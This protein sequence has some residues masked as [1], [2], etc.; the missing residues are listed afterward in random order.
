MVWDTVHYTQISLPLKYLAGLI[1]EVNS[2]GCSVDQI[3]A[4]VHKYTIKIE[5]NVSS[6]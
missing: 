6:V 5:I 3:I 4:S 2:S 1:V